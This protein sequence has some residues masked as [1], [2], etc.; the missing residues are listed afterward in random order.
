MR[1]YILEYSRYA[2][3]IILAIYTL[4]SYQMLFHPKD[5]GTQKVLGT[6]QAVLIA[7]FLGTGNLALAAGNRDLRFLL[8]GAAQ[9]LLILGAMI[10]FRVIYDFGNL[11]L[12]HNM[13]MMLSIGLVVIARISPSRSLKQ[14]SVALIGLILALLLPLTRKHFSILKLPQ[15]TYGCAF[16]GVIALGIVLI[17]GS[18]TQG[19]NLSYTL[20]GV[21]FQP[22]EF[23]KLLFVVFIAGMLKGAGEDRTGIL[24]SA[25]F[26]AAHVLILAASRDLGSAVI[27]FAVYVLVLFE[28]TGKWYVLPAG[29]LS[30]AAAAFAAYRLFSHVQVR[31]AAYLDPWSVIDSMGYQITQS[32]FAIA[33]G[34]PFGT[35]LTQG[36]PDKIPYALQD[37]IFAPIAEELGLIAG[38][39]II[40]LCLCCVLSMLFMSLNYADKFSQILTFAAAVSYGFQTFLTL[41]GETRFIPL[42]GVTLPLV[43]YGGSSV[44]STILL[45]TLV[46]TMAILQGERI[47]SFRRRFEREM[48]EAADRTRYPVE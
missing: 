12:F 43:S 42:T 44:L 37:F 9:I 32:L 41:G 3:A 31:V 34:G 28:A 26:A 24:I 47:D 45:F 39:S 1:L 46:E 23:V 2:I 22:S 20:F 36:T 16:A 4:L 19:A 29:A 38:V 30:G 8:L 5:A 6:V 13:C 25:A 10:L 17:L 21:T 11:L 14:F 33:F 35:G 18:V 48:D 15:V 40:L 27:F 7:A